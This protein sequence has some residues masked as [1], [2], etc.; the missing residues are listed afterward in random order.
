V[1]SF[2]II[3][4]GKRVGERNFALQKSDKFYFIQIIKVNKSV[5][6]ISY[7]E[8]GPIFLLSS[9]PQTIVQCNYYS[10]DRQI[11]KKEHSSKF[12]LFCL[13]GQQRKRCEKP[14]QH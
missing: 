12:S 10:N 8:T 4:N 1:T 9:S 5:P 2:K 7:E 6:L 14:S 3:Q 11:S 13:K